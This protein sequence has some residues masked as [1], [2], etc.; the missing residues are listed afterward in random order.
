MVHQLAIESTA[1]VLQCSP[2]ECRQCCSASMIAERLSNADWLTSGQWQQNSPGMAWK[3]IQ[4]IQK[5]SLKSTDCGPQTANKLQNMLPLLNHDFPITQTDRGSWIIWHCRYYKEKSLEKMFF[6]KRPKRGE[7]HRDNQCLQQNE[8]SMNDNFDLSLFCFLSFNLEIIK[9]A[10]TSLTKG[11][12]TS[13]AYSG[14]RV[15]KSQVLLCVCATYMVMFRTNLSAVACHT[16]IFPHTH[17]SGP[18][19]DILSG[20][21]FRKS[22]S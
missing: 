5:C 6:K 14:A 22:T 10:C 7:T 1:N 16:N 17:V 13:V 12:C 18:Q 9:F 19:S 3:N 2:P 20:S 11:L 4:N 21:P 8:K 15:L